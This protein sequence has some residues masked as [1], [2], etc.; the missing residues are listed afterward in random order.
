MKPFL[1][2]AI[3]LCVFQASFGQS[4]MKEG[5]SW[6]DYV[7]RAAIEFDHLEPVDS[8]FDYYEYRIDYHNK[9]RLFLL[10]TLNKRPMI[11]MVVL[12]SFSSEYVINLEE[13]NGTFIVT[14]VIADTSIWYS[15]NPDYVQNPEELV[16]KI[17]TRTISKSLAEKVSDLFETAMNQTQ[18][19]NDGII[20]TDGTSYYFTATGSFGWR[21][22][23][24]W[25][26]RE[27]TKINEL[28]RITETLISNELEEAELT[29][30]IE[31]LKSRF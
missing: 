14:K 26:P 8:Y 20:G 10:D 15:Q 1:T 4:G 22:A 19:N 12:P 18:Y 21:T 2:V 5:E 7:Q 6:G 24:K 16:V 27:G 31:N 13:L 11:R 29:E 9:I 30:E 17:E 23:T 3:L 28:I 25:S